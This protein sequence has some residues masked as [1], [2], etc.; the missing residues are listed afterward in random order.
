MPKYRRAETEQIDPYRQQPLPVDRPAAIYY[1]Q[2]SDA[3][4][5]NIN[6]TLQTVDMFERLVR[7]GWARDNILMIDMDAGISG[8]K[9]ISERPGL[10][11]LM[12]LIEN[13][14]IGLVAA[15]DVDR[16]FR[17]I[18]QIQTNIFI[19]ACKRN[20]VRVM[21]QRTVYDFTHP[22]MGAYDMKNFREEAQAA[23]DYLEYHIRGRLGRSREYLV[24]QG[25]WSGRSVAFG[26]M[27]DL[28]RKLPDGSRN[29]TYKKYVPFE[30]C[31]AVV[32]AYFSIFKRCNRNLKQTWEYIE[33]HG[34][35]VPE[36][37]EELVPEGFKINLIVK[38]RSPHTGRVMHSYSGLQS[39]FTNVVY[40]GHW[41]KKGVILY[42]H[43][44]EALVNEDDFM[45]AFNALSDVDFHG[46]PNPNYMPQRPFVRHDRAKRGCQPPVYA[47]LVFSDDVEGAPRRRMYSSYNHINDNYAYVLSNLRSEMVFRVKAD[48]LDEAIDRLLLQRLEA[49]TLD[50]TAWQAALES[51][52]RDG[53][54]EVRRMENEIRNAERTKVAIMENLKTLQN[55]EMVRQLQASYEA[56][57]RTIV[58]LMAEL[59][60]L[61]SG[62]RQ[63]QSLLDMRPVLEKIISNWGAVPA[64][65]RRELFEA[66]ASYVNV[67]ELDRL[68]RRMTIHWRDG[69]TSDF[70]FRRGAKRVFWSEEELN[71]MRQMVETAVPQWQIM[72][73]FPD[74]NWNMIVLRY[75]Y[76]FGEGSFAKVYQGEKKY[77]YS[78]YWKDTDEYQAEQSAFQ[79][80]TSLS[81]SQSDGNSPI[82][83]KPAHRQA[84]NDLAKADAVNGVGK[85]AACNVRWV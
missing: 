35:F 1:R 54:G 51:T 20:H 36:N 40:L 13:G 5:G 18:T 11:R 79:N 37:V 48:W 50:E 38:H 77:P 75:L 19:D 85:R 16:F 9:K 33:E 17:D 10:S 57:E 67:T 27:V 30:P 83:T 59:T 61:Q 28:R 31:A 44:H 80:H 45:C 4:I 15:Q 82:I 12:E 55:S 69:S 7:Q 23:A 22:T 63:R 53:Y 49:T 56:N 21:T 60:E 64:E 81:V 26:Y 8:S 76:H 52:R 72:K 66:L 46:D 62:S 29:P 41:V 43:N 71:H 14:D 73:T 25:L 65:N 42:Y 70:D 34:P 32:R 3:Q 39:M 47:G 84:V 2:S 6:T 68:N 58:R 74:C 24:D 78:A